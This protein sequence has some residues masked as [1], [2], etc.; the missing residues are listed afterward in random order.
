MSRLHNAQVN[1]DFNGFQASGALP[2]FGQHANSIGYFRTER[3]RSKSYASP[4]GYA[5]SAGL[6]SLVN[7]GSY[8]KR[9]PR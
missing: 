3:K 9:L 5:V 8:V 4:E 1:K 6:A 2:G 7:F